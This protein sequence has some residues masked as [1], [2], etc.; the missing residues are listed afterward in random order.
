ML[1]QTRRMAE[2]GREVAIFAGVE[3]MAGFA[4]RNALNERP[5]S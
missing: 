4:K 5:K 2:I 1:F 3:R